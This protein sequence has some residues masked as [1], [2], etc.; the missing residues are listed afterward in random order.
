MEKYD[1]RVLDLQNLLAQL[2]LKMTNN[3]EIWQRDWV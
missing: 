1:E 2:R 3:D